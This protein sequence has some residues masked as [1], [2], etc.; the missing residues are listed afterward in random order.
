M[1]HV[2]T[3]APPVEGIGAEKVVAL[4][5]GRLCLA[6]GPDGAYTLPSAAELEAQ[7]SS[8]LEIGMLD[9]NRCGVLELNDAPQRGDLKLLELRSALYS[10]PEAEKIA[11]GRA[12]SLTFWRRRG[13]FCGVCGGETSDS[14]HECARVCGSCGALFFP[15]LAP[16]V[17]VAVRRGDEILLAHNRKFTT[18]VYGLVA[19]F[20]EAGEDLEQTVRREV[21]E[22][23]N[24]AV[25]NI[26]YF[27]SQSWP[28]PNS[29]MV[30]FTA[31]Y[32][33]G[34]MRPDGVEIEDARW[35]RADNLPM[36]PA[37]GSIAHRMIT[38]FIDEMQGAK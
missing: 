28:F 36:I 9:G 20:V 37:P 4:V 15:V 35:C 27:G 16:A 1:S 19:G 32:L 18:P 29:L 17:I 21:M 23:V 8:A 26:R 25:G 2:F 33:H 5:G 38:S 34:D 7:S 3:P 22:E 13:R 24:I 12:L 6:V 30:G 31:D 10:L 11:I 14:E